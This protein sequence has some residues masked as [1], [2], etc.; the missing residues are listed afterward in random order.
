MRDEAVNQSGRPARKLAVREDARSGSNFE[1]CCSLLLALVRSVRVV[2]V[3]SNGRLAVLG[4]LGS[5]R[6]HEAQI[7][8]NEAPPRTRRPRPALHAGGGASLKWIR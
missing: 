3:G 6:P 8:R 4:H 7:R 1:H 5:G 2:V